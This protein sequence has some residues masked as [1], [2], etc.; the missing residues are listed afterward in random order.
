MADRSKELKRVERLETELRKKAG[1]AH[2]PLSGQ[3]VHWLCDW[4]RIGLNA[5]KSATEAEENDNTDWKARALAAEAK[6]NA[7][8][9]HSFRDAVVLEAAHQRQR[10]GTDHD[11]GKDVDDWLWLVAYLA[12]KASQAHRY[13]DGE[14]CLHHIIT[15]AAAC[16]NWHANTSG[17]NFEMRPGV[18]ADRLPSGPSEP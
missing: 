13:G 16:A 12:T 17:Q 1:Y 3:D 5:T 18:G 9:L 8:E 2:F 7:P 4:A 6:L 14:K 10:W 15:C 11:E